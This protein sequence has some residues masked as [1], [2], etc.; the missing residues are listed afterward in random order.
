MANLKTLKES[1]GLKTPE[2]VARKIVFWQLSDKELRPIIRAVASSN[3]E[4]I[5]DSLK[6][7]MQTAVNMMDDV[8][9]DIPFFKSVR[10]EVIKLLLKN[11]AKTNA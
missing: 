6:E 1:L 10:A 11:I 5:I 7:P 2:E 3:Q 4:A 9:W 8:V